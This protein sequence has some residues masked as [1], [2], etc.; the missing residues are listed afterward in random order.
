M[1]G[2]VCLTWLGENE[3]KR[4]NKQNVSYSDHSFSCISKCSKKTNIS[5]YH[6][7]RIHVC[8]Y[9]EDKSISFLEHFAHVL[10][11]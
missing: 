10:N 8:A 1:L 2:A 11:E 5:S 3:V 4:S 7:I 9:Q 6:M